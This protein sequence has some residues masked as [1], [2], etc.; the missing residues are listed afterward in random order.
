EASRVVACDGDFLDGGRLKM[1]ASKNI[2]VFLWMTQSAQ[3][4]QRRATGKIKA[5]SKAGGFNPL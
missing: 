5:V 3:P 4:E 1:I 2:P